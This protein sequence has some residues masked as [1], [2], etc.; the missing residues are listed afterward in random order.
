M[1]LLTP[2]FGLFAWTL[3]AFVIVFLLLKKFAWKPILTMLTERETT[4][5]NNIAAAEKVRAE[6][7]SMQAENEKLLA[8]AREERT[9]LLKEAK[10]TK[11]RIINEAK[12]QAKTEA[13]KIIA[14]A[15]MQIEQQRNAA[16]V[17]VKNEIGNLA[18]EVAEKVLRKEFAEGSEQRSYA[19][20]L[21]SEITLN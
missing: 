5:A 20:A 16:L 21:A 17:A 1:E 18:I 10:E 11:D 3:V 13:D 8:Q 15:H 7:A 19:K 12:D 14:A 4:I 6:M 2:A 9:Q